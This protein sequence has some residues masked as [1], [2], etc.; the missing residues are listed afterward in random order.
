MKDYLYKGIR[1][2]LFVLSLFSYLFL[3][4]NLDT[5][6]FDITSFSFLKHPGYN[7]EDVAT[8]IE[9]V[10]SLI[11]NNLRWQTNIIF[12]SL[13]ILLSSFMVYLIFM[14]KHFFYIA[15]SFYTLLGIVCVIMILIGLGM[16][17]SSTGYNYARLVKDQLIHTPFVFI[18]LVASLKTFIKPAD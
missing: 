11:S 8:S 18:L 14:K 3:G 13:M 12:T 6:I 10:T 4:Y 15:L 16:T 17:D 9:G 7:T 5:Y 2:V 1:T